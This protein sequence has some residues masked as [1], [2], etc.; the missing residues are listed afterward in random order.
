V[1][2]EERAR[3][4]TPCWQPQ[5]GGLCQCPMCMLRPLIAAQLREVRNEERESVVVYGRGRYI[6]GFR[7]AKKR[8]EEIVG[9]MI[10]EMM[11]NAPAHVEYM[12]RVL[13][14]IQAVEP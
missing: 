10:L 2:V 9:N 11:A 7:V 13:K 8:A 3:K 12:S 4:L 14:K 1:T 6:A 5:S